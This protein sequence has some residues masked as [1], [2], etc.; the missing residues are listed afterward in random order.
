MIVQTQDGV[1]ACESIIRKDRHTRI[2]SDS[3]LASHPNADSKYA[4]LESSL[5]F[6]VLVLNIVESREL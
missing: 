6:S 2:D 1:F 3:K 4:L 5:A